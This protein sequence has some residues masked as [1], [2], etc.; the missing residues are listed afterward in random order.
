MGDI[1]HLSL[2]S[3]LK[4]FV[5][6][7]CRKNCELEMLK[8]KIKILKVIKVLLDTPFLVFKPLYI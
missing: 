1:Y 3:N 7:T 5:L 2:T 4:I 8:R 6:H